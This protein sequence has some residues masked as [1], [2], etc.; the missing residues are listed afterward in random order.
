MISLTIAMCSI[1]SRYRTLA[2]KMQEQLWGQWRELSETDRTRVQILIV[3]DNKSMT[4]GAKRN[5]L[6]RMAS[7]KYIVFVD[8]DDR[9][10]DDYIA[11]ILAATESDCDTIVFQAMVS[12]GGAPAR[13]CD[14]SII[15]GGDYNTP[16]GY[17]RLPN[18]ICAVKREH[19]L[20]TPFADICMGE[21]SHYSARLLALLKTEARIE[22]PL[23]YYD[24]DPRTSESRR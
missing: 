9:I 4:T 6:V 8:D 7:G 3:T 11:A 23:Y 13:P 21:D 12:L 18:H 1:E 14:Y 10:A 22:K 24:Y 15:H 5:W 19:A 16:T 17:H 20:A 2:L